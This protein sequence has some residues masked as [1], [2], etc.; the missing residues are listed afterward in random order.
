MVLSNRLLSLTNKC[1][2]IKPS[3]KSNSKCGLIK[4]SNKSNV[5]VVLSNR[6]I[7][8]TSVVLS[9]RLVSPISKR[10]L[11]K[12]STS[13]SAQQYEWPI[14]LQYHR[15]LAKTSFDEILDLTADCFIIITLNT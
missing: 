6:L 2:L 10:G 11:I 4:P 12:P 8:L 13:V 1:G 7:S 3:S 15:P 9:N 5:S 14:S